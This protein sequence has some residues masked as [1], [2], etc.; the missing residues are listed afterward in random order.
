VGPRADLDRR[1]ISSSPGFDPGQISQ[2]NIF[3]NLLLLLA[4]TL[5]PAVGFALSNNVLPFFSICHQL[6]PS[7]HSQRLKIFSKSV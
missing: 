4:L 6:S 1:K 2:N 5:Q 3:K 7:A